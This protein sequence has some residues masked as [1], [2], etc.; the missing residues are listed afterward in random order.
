MSKPNNKAIDAS[1]EPASYADHIE[2]EFSDKYNRNS[3]LVG[4]LRN[5]HSKY[6]TNNLP[7]PV[8]VSILDGENEGLRSRQFAVA[9]NE[10]IDPC[11]INALK[12]KCDTG[13]TRLIFI[14]YRS[15]E[16]L[17][18]ACLDLIG[19][20]CGLHPDFF[21]VHFECDFDQTGRFITHYPSHSLPSERRFLQIKTDEWTFMTATWKISQA[22]RT[23]ERDRCEIFPGVD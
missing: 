14:Q 2:A 5:S 21:S 11:L 13:Q 19:T 15:F 7:L 17:N 23:C 3:W 10:P 12:E 22:Q 20:H 16:S 18:P 9:N 6:T 1:M 4:F 8:Q